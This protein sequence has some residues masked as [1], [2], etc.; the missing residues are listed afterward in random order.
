MNI[1]LPLSSAP[2]VSVIIPSS[3]RLD[4][5]HAC[6]Q[7]LARFGP[8]AIPYETIVV[9]NEAIPEAESRLRGMATGIQVASSTVNLGLAGAGNRGRALA[10]GELLILLH[11]DAEIEAGWMEALVETADAHPGAG[12]IGGKVLHPTGELQWAGGILWREA[13]VSRP[14]VGETP[15]P[16]ALDRL[17]A[18]DFC[19]SSSLLVRAALWDLIGGLDEQFYPVNFVDV[20]LCMA[21]RKL[22][23]LVLYQPNSCIRHHQSAS[24][25]PRFKEF[26]IR[27]NRLLFLKK[28]GAALENHEPYECSSAAVERASARAEMFA[29]QCRRKG[30]MKIEEPVGPKKFDVAEQHFR[31]VKKS[32]A[33]HKAFAIDQARRSFS[34]STRRVVRSLTGEK[35]YEQAKRNKKIFTLFAHLERFLGVRRP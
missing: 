4:L 3:T 27:R 9:L 5:L 34:E 23:F 10:R 20:D 15:A 28:W 21:I 35:L 8:A 26:L 29:D 16:N 11:D 2:R 17:R 22:G 12:A 18:V 24:T 6:L 30:K 7:S 13:Y 33:L 32:R 31:H 14:W 1:D 19:C 25:E